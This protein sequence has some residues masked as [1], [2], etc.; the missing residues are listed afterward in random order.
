[1]TRLRVFPSRFGHPLGMGS[2]AGYPVEKR[3]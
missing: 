1:L 2:G 3:I